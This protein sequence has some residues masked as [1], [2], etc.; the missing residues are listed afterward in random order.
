MAAQ[1]DADH[2]HGVEML[3]HDVS[4]GVIPDGTSLSILARLRK[5]EE[6]THMARVTDRPTKAT[7]SRQGIVAGGSWG[8]RGYYL[9][10]KFLLI[11]MELRGLWRSFFGIL[12]SVR[13]RL[14]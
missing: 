10:L 8:R 7:E 14:P 11:A 3:Q 4:S 12:V 5:S 2:A 1:D 6:E 13:C 9:A